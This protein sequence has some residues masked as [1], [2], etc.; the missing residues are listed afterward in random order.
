[1]DLITTLVIDSVWENVAFGASVLVL[2]NTV[3]L[4]VALNASV[5]TG[6][7]NVK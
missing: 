3:C 4:K 1:M 2:F 5:E 6:H 7:K